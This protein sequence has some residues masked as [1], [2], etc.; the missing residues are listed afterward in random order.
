M[1]DRAVTAI[2]GTST[3]HDIGTYRRRAPA[4]NLYKQGSIIPRSLQQTLQA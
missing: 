2:S 4:R 3:A 1:L